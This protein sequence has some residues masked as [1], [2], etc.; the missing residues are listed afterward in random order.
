[1][2]GSRRH[3][4][5]FLAV[6]ALAG[7]LL[8][9][10]AGVGGE[11]V[12]ARV[13]AVGIPGAGAV[14]A[15]GRF[16]PGGPISDNPAFQAYTGPGKVLQADRVLVGSTSNFG[17]AKAVETDLPGSILSV[18]PTGPEPLRVPP[19]FA[20]SGGQAATADGRIQLFSA[21]TAAFLNGVTSPQAATAGDPG[22]SNPL[23]LSIN[24]A[25]GRLWPANAPRGLDGASSESILDP[26]GMP[27]AKA[28]SARAGGVFAGAVTNR[29]PAQVIPGALGAG[30]VGTAFIGRALDDPKRAVF[31]VVTADGAIEQAHTQQGVDGL[32]PAGTISDLRGRADSTELHVGAVLKYYAPEPVLYVSDP[33]AD[34]VV[35]VTLPKDQTGTVRRPG[36]IRHFGNAAFDMPVDLAPTTPEG[37]HRDWSS[38]TTLAELADIYVLNRGNNTIARMKDDG[39]VIASRTIVLPGGRSLGSAKVNGIA[40][41][42]DGA[43]I[44]VT[45]TGA[46]PGRAEQGALLELPGFTGRPGPGAE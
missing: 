17:A 31:A 20:T 45:V 42:P 10:C 8:A 11:T 5:R 28:P 7:P 25:F 29:E 14:A 18:D 46:L 6:T 34:E 3:G 40:T 36:T 41:S 15:V 9:A 43:T 4:V 38:N 22:V 27:L 44:Y 19:D 35:A 26:G 21:Q 30:A 33:V 32:A 12:T 24:N 1:M 2:A 13:V 39:T 23:D 16:L 37:G